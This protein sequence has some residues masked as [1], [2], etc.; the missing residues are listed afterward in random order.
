MDR[1]DQLSVASEPFASPVG[2]RIY[3]DNVDQDSVAADAFAT[4]D[5]CN[6]CDAPTTLSATIA[7]HVPLTPLETAHL[8][9]NRTVLSLLPLVRSALPDAVLLRLLLYLSEL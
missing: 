1:V 5:D 6:D 3:T 7:A 8:P 2:A 4:C 9:T